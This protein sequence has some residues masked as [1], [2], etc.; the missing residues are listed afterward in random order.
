MQTKYFDA[1]CALSEMVIESSNELKWKT[2]QLEL[3]DKEIEKLRT[4]LECVE[5]FIDKVSKRK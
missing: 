2:T 1:I 3:R 5:N 4:K